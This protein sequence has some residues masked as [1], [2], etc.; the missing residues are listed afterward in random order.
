MLQ[1][2]TGEVESRPRCLDSRCSTLSM[3]S[4]PSSPCSV[5]MKDGSPAHPPQ[6]W[7]PGCGDGGQTGSH[8]CIWGN[9]HP[10]RVALKQALGKVADKH[11]GPGRGLAC[12]GWGRSH[13]EAGVDWDP[14]PTTLKV[15]HCPCATEPWTSH[16]CAQESSSVVAGD[17]S[18]ALDARSRGRKASD[19]SSA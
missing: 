14:C 3:D 17:R 9:P 6:G 5:E 18:E 19:S 2:T 10:I 12:L 1:L 7:A 16:L 15:L 13:W 4:F 11:I 8:G